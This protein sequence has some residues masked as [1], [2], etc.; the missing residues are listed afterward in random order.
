MTE[1]AR[2]AVDSAELLIITAPAYV[3]A[4]AL[5]RLA[6][7]ITGT[8]RLKVVPTYQGEEG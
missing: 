7:A 1:I 6:R 5:Y 4:S 8:I 2:A 3:L